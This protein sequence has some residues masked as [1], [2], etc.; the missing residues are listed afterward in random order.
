MPDIPTPALVVAAIVI[1]LMLLVVRRLWRGRRRL[2]EAPEPTVPDIDIGLLGSSGPPRTGIQ[3]E[4]YHVPV[5]LAVLVLAPVGRDSVL[6]SKEKLPEMVDQLLPGML[7]VLQSHQPLFQRWPAQLSSKGFA[8]VLFSHAKLPGD[9]GKGTPWCS[10]A[11]KF[12]A[13]NENYLAGL[14]C[15]AD[16]PNALGQIEVEQTG[17]WLDVLRV[18]R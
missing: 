3:L 18:R 9:G 15:C 5:R 2:P 6:P 13:N 14:V 12:Q 4:C 1:V 10:I 17:Q 7:D 8:R 11:G 16:R